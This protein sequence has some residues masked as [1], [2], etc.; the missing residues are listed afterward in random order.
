MITSIEQ[1]KQDS[2]YAN[3]V[4]INSRFFAADVLFTNGKYGNR[5]IYCIKNG[6]VFATTASLNIRQL[7]CGTLKKTTHYQLW[8]S[9]ELLRGAWQPRN[10]PYRKYVKQLMHAIAIVGQSKDFYTTA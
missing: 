1:V 2:N 5:S 3:V 8:R 9:G 6:K 10:K 4:A 7:R